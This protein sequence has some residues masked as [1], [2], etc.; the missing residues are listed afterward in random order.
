MAKIIVETTKEEQEKVLK[1]LAELNGEVTPVAAIA[2]R[3]GLRQTRARY[4]IMDL[5][6][7]G[8]IE[9]VASKAFN[10]HYVRYSY[11]VLK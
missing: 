7:Q 9:R 10:K 2:S 1:V 3:A 5:I 4:V 6:D 11:M 8:K